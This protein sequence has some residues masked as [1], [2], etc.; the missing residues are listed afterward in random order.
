MFG[1]LVCDPLHLD[2]TN[3]DLYRQGYCGLCNRLEAAYGNTGRK[4]LSYDMTFVALL[5]SAVFNSENITG[6]EKCPIHPIR[7]HNYFYNE[8]FSYAA[9]INILFT[10]YKH[11]DDYHDENSSKALKQAQQL[12]PFVD[13][14]RNKY[15]EKVKVIEKC[16]ND[17]TAMEKANVNNPDLP[18]N[19]FGYLMAEVLD[20][21]EELKHFGFEL[22]RVI[23][24]MDGC[25][26]LSDDL[27]HGQYNPFMF[28]DTDKETVMEAVMAD[29]LEEYKR[30]PVSLYKDILENV[31]Y[32]GIWLK[33]DAKYKKGKAHE[34][35]L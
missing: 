5:L 11:L 14:I 4:T 22:G 20:Q 7:K 28:I 33:Y 10:Y 35:S 30:L 34:R 32:C 29:C 16:L 23:Y 15:P 8:Y 9:D 25:V 6:E 3:R 24:L 2:K 13:E 31:L 27:K 17:I 21:S 26:D 12:E 19:C 18:A 1:Y